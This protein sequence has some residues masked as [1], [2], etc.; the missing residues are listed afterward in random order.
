MRE[1]GKKALRQLLE[2]LTSENFKKISINSF[3]PTLAIN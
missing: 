2:A 3:S 1:T